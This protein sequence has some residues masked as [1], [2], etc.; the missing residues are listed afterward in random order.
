MQ[1]KF[2]FDIVAVM[3][4]H[5]A[6]SIRTL[7]ILH[8]YKILNAIPHL[9]DFVGVEIYLPSKEMPSQ[10]IA[11]CLKIIKYVSSYIIVRCKQKV[12]IH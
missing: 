6:S 12:N 4:D 1:R 2:C 11:N 10:N 8:D 5:I 3:T 7:I 9:L